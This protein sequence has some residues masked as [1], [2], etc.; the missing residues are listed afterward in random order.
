MK[1]FDRIYQLH[2]ILGARHYPVSMQ[3]LCDA[4]ECSPATVKRYLTLLREQFGAPVFNVRGRGWCYDRGHAFELPGLWFTADEL[5]AL[6]AIQ[7][8]LGSLQPG[9]L[10]EA[11]QPVA[12]RVDELLARAVPAAAE[13]MERIRLLGMMPRARRLPHFAVVAGA[14]VARKRLRMTYHARSSDEVSE[15]EVSPQRLV[16]YRDNWYLDAWCHLRK[17][18]RS[19]AIERITRAEKLGRKARDIAASRLDRHFATAYGIFAGEAD[20]EVVLRFLPHAAR[21]VADETWHPAQVGRRLADGSY[22]LRIPYGDPTELVLDICRHGP[23]VEVL[24]PRSL[25]RAVAERLGR[26]AAQ[27]G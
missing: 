5:A 2:H 18:L 7:R 22:E 24:A 12:R 8:L 9:L 3:A 27:Y 10:D 16:H 25:R 14:V 11:L 4:M 21:W 13:Q 17:G 20:K 1:A 15:R 6:L 23:D 19:F 26:A